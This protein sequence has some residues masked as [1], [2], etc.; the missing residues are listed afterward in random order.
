M[1]SHTHTRTE[2]I[3]H[4]KAHTTTNEHASAIIINAII[5]LESLLRSLLPPRSRSFSLPLTRS[6]CN[7]YFQFS[8][9]RLQQLNNN[10]NN[11]NCNANRRVKWIK[12]FL[13]LYAKWNLN[14]R[15]L[16]KEGAKVRCGCLWEIAKVFTCVCKLNYANQINVKSVKRHNKIRKTTERK[17]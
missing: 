1:C 7:F 16:S 2:W 11:N 13:K 17:R 4:C 10:N 14:C 9:F 15:F 3:Q 12:R 8:L 6:V 5:P